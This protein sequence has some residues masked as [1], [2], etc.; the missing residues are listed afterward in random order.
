MYTIPSTM[1]INITYKI[2]EQHNVQI[3][4]NNSQLASSD[5]INQQ[6]ENQS[7][8]R[9]SQTSQTIVFHWTKIM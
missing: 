2:S 3:A 8:G 6:V 5:I 4:N 9:S 1:I 7:T